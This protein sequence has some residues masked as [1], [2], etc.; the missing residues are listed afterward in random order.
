MYEPPKEAPAPV[1]TTVWQV[2]R[3]PHRV[4]MIPG[5][6]ADWIAVSAPAGGISE[7]VVGLNS[8]T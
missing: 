3:A 7:A 5:L 1:R 2:V 4:V 8:L 6:N